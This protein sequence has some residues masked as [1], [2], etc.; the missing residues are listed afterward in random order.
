MNSALLVTC[1]GVVGL[2]AGWW[3]ARLTLRSRASREAGRLRDEARTD[4]LTG[5][6][7]RRALDEQLQ[8]AV[9]RV[10]AV[11]V[12]LDVDGL[13]RINDAQG[14]A[15]GDRGLQLVAGAL[16]RS[17]RSGDMACR[18]GG[19]EFALLLLATDLQG[20]QQ[21]VGRVLEALDGLEPPVRVSLGI[22]QLGDALSAAWERADEALYAAKEAG[23][24]AVAY[25]DGSRC[26]VLPAAGETIPPLPV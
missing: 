6:W 23:G 24:D 22:V 7:N 17:V 14:H 11:L 3:L 12:L 26:Q 16:Q 2:I 25:H 15:A 9:G 21:V 19:D 13:K 18:W 1:G 10:L 4:P 20:G 5:L 8:E